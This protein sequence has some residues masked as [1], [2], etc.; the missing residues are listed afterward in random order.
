[1]LDK[2]KHNWKNILIFILLIFGLNKCTQSCNRQTTIDK[3]TKT[4]L[5][6]DS[7][8]T[9]KNSE[10]TALKRDTC[11]YLNRIRMYDKFGKQTDEYIRQRNRTDSINAVNSARQKAQT[12]ELIKQNRE[13]INKTNK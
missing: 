1:M 12:D 3:Q 5:T 6:L 11:E 9:S 7:T 13:L 10:I 2:I 4:I 8:L